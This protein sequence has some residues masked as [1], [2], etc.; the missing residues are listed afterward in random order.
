MNS[1]EK[2]KWGKLFKNLG[3]S[4]ERM[5]EANPM[6]TGKITDLSS[7]TSPDSSSI[8]QEKEES[9]KMTSGKQ[10]TLKPLSD[11]KIYSG[12]LLTGVLQDSTEQKESTLVFEVNFKEGINQI[13]KALIP[14]ISETE[15]WK[16][17]VKRTFYHNALQLKRIL[18]NS[19][20]KV[21][22]FRKSHE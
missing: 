22:V 20:L 21:I 6:T 5:R 18:P 14:E 17:S 10:S 19:S 4:R 7:A 8:S 15:T 9:T 12:E 11:Q 16:D 3:E 13:G 1:W 2:E